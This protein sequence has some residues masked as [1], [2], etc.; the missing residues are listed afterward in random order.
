MKIGKQEID[1]NLIILLA[2]L[3]VGYVLYN[4]I[5]GK[6]KDESTIDDLDE[7]I[8]SILDFPTYAKKMG[9]KYGAKKFASA[10][11]AGGS[12][13]IR[14]AAEVLDDVLDEYYITDQ[15]EGAAIA[16]LNS[17]SNKAQISFLSKV[18]FD[19]YKRSLQQD[20]INGLDDEPL[21]RAYKVINN[22]PAI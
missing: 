20:L 18:Y 4:K 2:A 10:V 16:A 19:K 8:S 11:I 6:D 17:M 21:A 5:F 22:K 9:A 14:K 12:E 13:K 1:T 7:P 3:G 15:Q